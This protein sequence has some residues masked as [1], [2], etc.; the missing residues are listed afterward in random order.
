M[1]I[2]LYETCL[3]IGGV[4]GA[5]VNKGTYTMTTRWAYRIPL[6]TTMIFPTVLVSVIWL[7]PES[8]RKS[9]SPFFLFQLY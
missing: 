1:A 7:F 4:V 2:G 6:I 9:K 5:C 3:H 8:P